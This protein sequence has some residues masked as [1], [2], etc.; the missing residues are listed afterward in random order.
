[1]PTTAGSV[2]LWWKGKKTSLVT[3]GNF[4]LPAR[5]VSFSQI[6]WT[7]TTYRITYNRPVEKLVR[8]IEAIGLQQAIVLQEIKSNHYRIVAGYRRLLALQKIRTDPVSCKIADFETGNKQLFFFNF[9]DN[10]DRGFN[11]VELSWVLM[12][13][14]AFLEEK[15]LIHNYLPLLNLPPRKETVDRLLRLNEISPIFRPALLEGRLFPE[16]VEKVV[17]DFSPIAHLI[18][19]LFIFLHWGFQKQKEF[20]SDLREICSRRREEPEKIFSGLPIEELL[21]HFSW[22]PQQKGESL[23]KF[24]RTSLFP[25]LTETEKRFEE[26]IAPLNMDP[27]TRIYPPPF[28]EG[29][30]YGLDVRFSNPNELKASLEKILQILEDRKLD[31]LP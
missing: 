30:R 4:D 18:L 12:K 14:S 1:M 23:R 5:R 20:L 6:D 25:I 28:F 22:T 3:K 26:I 21:N 13:L 29:G 7:D 15:E 17:R 9:L 10:L 16:T 11:V 2:V 27:G 8:S 19:A 31:E 24:F